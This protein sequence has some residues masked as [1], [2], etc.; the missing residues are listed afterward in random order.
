MKKI[1]FT[2]L[3]GVLISISAMAQSKNEARALRITNNKIE[4][5]E[6]ITEL[7]DSEKETFFEL[8][9]VYLQKH[10]DLKELKKSDPA[11]YKTERKA[12]K[13]DF[14]KKLTV[15]LGKERATE[16]TKAGKKKK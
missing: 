5:I 14:M 8:N 13:A 2:L 6:Q 7:S 16:I 1:I 12:N 3:V 10:F 9:K 4:Q 15:A 11:K